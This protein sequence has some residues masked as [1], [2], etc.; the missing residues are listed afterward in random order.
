MKRSVD[1]ALFMPMPT[2]YPQHPPYYPNNVQN[3]SAPY[4]YNHNQVPIIKNYEINAS[5]PMLNHARVSHIYEDALPANQFMN[6]SNTLNERINMYNFIRSTFIKHS[7]GEDIDISGNK[8]HSLLSYLKFLDLNPYDTSYWTNNPYKSLPKDT[9]MYK[10]CY[11]IRYNKGT[12]QTE[13]AMNSVGMNVKIIK[14][15]NEEY[16]SRN[17]QSGNIFDHDI[18]REITFYEMLKENILKENVSPNFPLMYAYYICQNCEIDFA[19]IDKI[20]GENNANKISPMKS[21]QINNTQNVGKYGLGYANNYISK[22][23]IAEYESPLLIAFND[24]SEISVLSNNYKFEMVYDDYKFKTVTAAYYASNY[25]KSEKYE[26]INVWLQFS[27]TISGKEAKKLNEKIKLNSTNIL[28]NKIKIMK[29][30]IKI[31]FSS[32]LKKTLLDT[33]GAHIICHASKKNEKFWSDNFDGTGANNLG[34][35][36]MIERKNLGGNAGITMKDKNAYNDNIKNRILVSSQSGGDYGNNRPNNFPKPVNSV[37][38]VNSVNPANPVKSSNPGNIANFDNYVSNP[39][40]I[41]DHNYNADIKKPHKYTNPTTLITNTAITSTIKRNQIPLLNM[42]KNNMNKN[43]NTVIEDNPKAYSGKAVI[44]LSEAPN[45]NIIGW[46]SKRYEFYGNVKKMITTGYYD[47]Y[48][49]KSVIF[50]IMSGFLVLQKYKI[51]FNN[52]TAQDNI[53]IKDTKTHHN[54]NNYWKYVVDGIEYYIPNYG[55]LVLFDSN[56]KDI[57][58]ASTLL[59]IN[60]NN[61]N[62]KIFKLNSQHF[63][64]NNKNI[65]FDKNNLEDLLKVININVFSK[66]FASNGGTLPPENIIKLMETI[67]EAGNKMLVQNK[68]DIEELIRSQMS[69]FMHNRIGGFLKQYEINN[70]RKDNNKEFMKGDMLCF[71]ERND[72]YKFVIYIRTDINSNAVILTKNNPK[73]TDMIENTIPIANLFAYSVHSTIS[74]EFKPNEF[75]FSANNLLETYT[76]KN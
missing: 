49:W 3:M 67:N 40:N 26:G 43:V 38:S 32:N 56:Y 5:G 44:T 21:H 52:F 20:K 16:N 7:D 62:D 48:I 58:K 31:K 17:I 8:E 11:P 59:S 74:Q 51:L 71:N 29:Q 61:N 46:A 47:D 75:N 64:Q 76:I 6:T 63:S 35:I 68:F 60:N 15:S 50:Q 28:T 70:V 53:Y 24:D 14:L 33:N 39:L 42:N 18:W 69:F 45:Y 25:D 66:V 22:Y 30:I 41:Y 10:S 12:N 2:S 19:Q 13:C 34:E 27:N 1:P 9:L 55:Y 36:L 23:N 4:M 65:N 72:I 57:V 54:T 37:N 73:D